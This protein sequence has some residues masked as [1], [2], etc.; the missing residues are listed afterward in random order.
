MKRTLYLAYGSNLNLLQMSQRCPGA[1][2][3]LRATLENY[4][5]VFRGSRGWAVAT[6]EPCEGSTVPCLLWSITEADEREL[7]IYEGFP[8][9]YTKEILQVLTEDGRELSAMAYIM[10]PGYPMG[11][12]VMS[13]LDTIAGGYKRLG[14]D[15]E[16]LYQS[17]FRSRLEGKV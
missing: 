11:I 6:V 7:D 8:R 15:L 14:F 5:L 10:A 1:R 16:S 3:M 2:P 17:A 12:P 13:Y 9:L 4:Q